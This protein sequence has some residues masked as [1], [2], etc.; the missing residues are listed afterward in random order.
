[1][2]R[3]CVDA[4]CAVPPR[5]CTFCARTAQRV[6][7]VFTRQ[8]ID[9]AH[10]VSRIR[11]CD[12]EVL[13]EPWQEG[14]NKG[15]QDGKQGVIDSIFKTGLDATTMIE[16]KKPT[17]FAT[18]SRTSCSSRRL[19]PTSWYGASGKMSGQRRRRQTK[20]INGQDLKAHLR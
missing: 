16:S 3:R 4:R 9:P 15:R 20:S 12:D 10:N 13:P 8:Y 19:W 7:L 6:R 14:A 2:L 1:M 11:G 17:C 5:G 18:I